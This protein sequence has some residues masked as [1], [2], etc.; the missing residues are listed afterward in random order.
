ML[1]SEKSKNYRF[2]ARR[3]GVL[4]FTRFLSKIKMI[5]KVKHILISIESNRFEKGLLD[6]FLFVIICLMPCKNY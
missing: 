5:N 4:N 6:K 3:K 2:H 1:N